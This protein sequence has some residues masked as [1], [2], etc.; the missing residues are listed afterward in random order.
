MAASRRGD[1]TQMR[2]GKL[3]VAPTVLWLSFFFV[4][5]LLIVVAVSFAS[6]TPYG[7]VIFD[8]TLGNYAR[9]TETLYLSIF[10]DTLIVAVITTFVTILLGYLLASLIDLLPKNGNNPV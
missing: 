10:A 8:W 4:V 3:M 7:Q 6:R 2:N 9:F 5:P 1:R